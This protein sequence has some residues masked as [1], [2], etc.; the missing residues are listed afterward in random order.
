MPFH[1]VKVLAFFASYT[2][3][4]VTAVH[5]QSLNKSLIES[6]ILINIDSI[7]DKENY[8]PSGR[9]VLSAIQESEIENSI[10]FEKL[11]PELDE[12]QDLID[13]MKAVFQNINIEQSEEALSHAVDYLAKNRVAFLMSCIFES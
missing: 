4:A 8:L 6:T 9:R 7:K 12:S 13:G 10:Q 3:T 11:E 1:K 2:V 5:S